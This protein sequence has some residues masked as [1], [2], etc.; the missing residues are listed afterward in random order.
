VLTSRVRGTQMCHLCLTVMC[1][2]AI[3]LLV[4]MSNYLCRVIL[5]SKGPNCTN[6]TSLKSGNYHL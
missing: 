2:I 6:I 4:L 3:P 5:L 1:Q